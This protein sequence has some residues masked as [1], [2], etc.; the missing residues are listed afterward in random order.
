MFPFKHLSF[1]RTN[2]YNSN[3]VIVEVSTLLKNS[4]LLLF[5]IIIKFDSQNFPALRA[6]TP[7]SPSYVTAWERGHPCAQHKLTD[8]VACD[9]NFSLYTVNWVW[10]Q[11]LFIS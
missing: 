10:K 4:L 1:C 7:I 2:I 6:V 5:I 11:A 3:F 8:I 9:N